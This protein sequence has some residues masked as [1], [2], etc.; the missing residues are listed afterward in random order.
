M[1]LG[2]NPRKRVGFIGDNNL[3][4]REEHSAI[5]RRIA[6]LLKC[7]SE[8]ANIGSLLPDIDVYPPLKHRKTLHNPIIPILLARLDRSVA[9]GYLSH[10]VADDFPLPTR[11]LHLFLKTLGGAEK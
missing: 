6:R 7:D 3:P 1:K 2:R 8:L 10:I 4:S 9:L 5:A 11:L